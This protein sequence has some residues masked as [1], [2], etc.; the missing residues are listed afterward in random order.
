MNRR[1]RLPFVP[2]LALTLV[3]STL[4]A[5]AQAELDDAN[6]V[7]ATYTV[8]AGM[9]TGTP[10]SEHRAIWAAVGVLVPP[11]LLGLIDTLEFFEI[12]ESF[13]DEQTSTDAYATLHEDGVNFTLGLNLT[14]AK[15]AFIDRNPDDVATFR[16][17]V[18][19]EF[20]HVLSFQENQR[21]PTDAV[22][23]TLVIDEGRLLPQSYLNL[24][25]DQFWKKAYP[26]HGPTTTSDADGSAL[27]QTNPTAFVTEY[28]ATGPLEDFAE[29]FAF[30]VTDPLPKGKAIKDQKVRFFAGFPELVKLQA[31]MRRGMR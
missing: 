13:K 30:F 26:D 4:P 19:H 27:Y 23:G 5:A 22:T 20:G 10:T 31:Q 15:A 9:L 11:S 6:N 25:Y 7:V 14:S 29:S 18:Y 1:R 3:W 2:L 16:Q 24:Y 21:D 8:H 28:A 17:T 12:P